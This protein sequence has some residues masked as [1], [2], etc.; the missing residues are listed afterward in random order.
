MQDGT[1]DVKTGAQGAQIDAR[2]GQDAGFDRD[3]DGIPC[4]FS[5]DA[6]PGESTKENRCLA[7]PLSIPLSQPAPP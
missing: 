5:V 6:D 7:L 1:S 3:L 4:A 2:Q